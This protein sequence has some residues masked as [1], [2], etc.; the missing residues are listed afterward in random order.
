MLRQVAWY[1]CPVTKL[2]P[3]EKEKRSEKEHVWS[4]SCLVPVVA[5]LKIYLKIK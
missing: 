5:I 2:D 3:F 1:V 4:F